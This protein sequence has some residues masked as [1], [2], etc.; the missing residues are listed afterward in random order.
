MI[1]SETEVNPLNAPAIALLKKCL[2]CNAEKANDAFYSKGEGRLESRCKTCQLKKKNQRRTRSEHN[3]IKNITT[4][5]SHR[6]RSWE[7][8]PSPDVTNRS[9]KT[10]NEQP[11]SSIPSMPPVD[12]CDFWEVR[13][14]SSISAQDQLEISLN[15]RS[16]VEILRKSHK[17]MLK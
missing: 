11:C 6:H 8:C 14:K 2:Q 1:K 17:A 9:K 15:L 4:P 7:N 16:F 13:Y 12:Q 10:V 3:W 5:K